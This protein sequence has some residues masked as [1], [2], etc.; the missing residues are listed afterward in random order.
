MDYEEKLK[1][2]LNIEKL[3]KAIADEYNIGAICLNTKAIKAAL[4]QCCND[5]K[6][7]YSREL[8]RTT[9]DNSKKLDELIKSFQQKLKQQPDK[10]QE[11]KEVVSTIDDIRR[12]EG[13]IEMYLKPYVELYNLVQQHSKESFLD[14]ILS[15][16][17]FDRMWQEVLI[18][19]GKIR[20][21]LQNQ[22]LLFR[23][24]LFNDINSLKKQVVDLKEEY[25]R[26]GT[27]QAKSPED[28]HDRIE[29]FRTKMERNY[30][31]YQIRVFLN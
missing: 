12:N 6:N 8:Q 26:E 13:E 27:P 15:K 5:W 21:T 7:A 11:L 23:K 10:I 2:Y 18:K 17:N 25:D 20:D 3:I 1:E 9:R 29:R 4:D 24:K 22:Q 28:A 19:A 14:K 30:L 16:T 31:I